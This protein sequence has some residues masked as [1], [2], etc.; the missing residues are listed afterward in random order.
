MLTVNKSTSKWSKIE[1]KTLKDIQCQVLKTESNS[2]MQ[3]VLPFAS[4]EDWIPRKAN[5]EWVGMDGSTAVS[6]S[7][8]QPFPF[9]ILSRLLLCMCAMM[10]FRTGK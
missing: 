10:T 3:Y 5:H 7:C 1:Y 4:F 6:S 2:W 8:L 9:A